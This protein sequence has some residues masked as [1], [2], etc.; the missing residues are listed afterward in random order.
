MNLEQTKTK[1]GLNVLYIDQ[2]DATAGSV[3]MWFR[4]GSA[5][6][7]K[8]DFGVAHFLE[9]MF[10]KG[11]KKRPGAKIADE[12]ESFGGEL[13]AFTSFDFTCYYVNCPKSQLSK[14]VDIILDMVAN[15]QFLQSELIP[16]RG[17]VLEEFKRSIDSP[18]QYAF[19]ELQDNFFSG[20]Y[21]HQILGTEKNIKSFTRDQIVRFRKKYYN[22]ENAL[23][24]VAGDL[25][26]RK[27]ITTLIDKF[28]LPS[29]QKS[30]FSPFELKSKKQFSGHL[31]EVGNTTLQICFEASNYD[32]KEAV[33]EELAL[34]LLGHGESSYLGRKLVYET[35]VANAVHT[36]PL[37]MAKNGIYFLR[38]N[39][40]TENLSQVLKNLEEELKLILKKGI[41]AEDIEKAKF[42]GRTS[43][44]YDLETI[45]AYA[46]SLGNG[47]AQNGDIRS[48]NNFIDR[49]QDVTDQ[50]IKSAMKRILA[51][52]KWFYQ[53]QL[54][55]SENLEKSIGKVSSFDQKLKN[56]L[57]K[58]KDTIKANSPTSEFNKQ[59]QVKT[60]IPGVKLIHRHSSLSKTFNLQ[61]YIKGGLTEENKNSNGKYN[62]LT[63]LL[64]ADTMNK[65]KDESKF[66]FESLAATFSSFCGKNA[67]GLNLS[68]ICE[69]FNELSNQFFDH[70]LN[71]TFNQKDLEFEKLMVKQSLIAQKEDPVRQCFDEVSKIAFGNHPYN[72]KNMGTLE[73][74]ESIELNSLKDLHEG[75]ISNQNL[76]FVYSGPHT[77]ENVTNCISENISNLKKRSSFQ[78]T[79]IKKYSP[80]KIL[81]S[82]LSFDREQTHIFIGKP[83]KKLESKDTI[84]FKLIHTY[85]YGQSSP[86]FTELR[87]K[88]GLCYSVSPVNFNA[89]E[90]G[91]FGIYV[92]CSNGKVKD[93]ITEIN[94]ILSKLREEGLSKSNFKKLIK[95]SV[96]QFELGLQ[97]N[98]DYCNTF[99]TP[100]L[101]GIGLDYYFK[102][103]EQ[104]KDLQYEDFQNGIKKSLGGK[105][106][107]II[108]GANQE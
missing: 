22:K 63:G 108:S 40:P 43:K 54:P 56:S 50:E 20:G 82:Q 9:H 14:S 33:A 10:F 57:N 51:K 58:I 25:K 45:E 78:K 72:M 95:M 99:A 55:K 1:K 59:T 27:K 23:F 64:N 89:L 83:T 101:H 105:F 2:P 67:Y 46:F 41:K 61:V 6:E 11:T 96:G 28:S 7:K 4:A 87:D 60:T 84:Y 62:L 29:G 68:G 19:T 5:L 30:V 37:Y 90:G 91:Y 48:E 103:M 65:T 24:V 31:K 85:L 97:T 17:V 76:L 47:F 98:E 16:E 49:Q 18:S 44:I 107:Q 86:L 53:I 69:K 100:Y 42:Q 21:K 104:I 52:T 38:L 74:I 8:E 3:Q 70:L 66:F 102:E 88:K 35:S 93:S 34:S 13:N 12:V 73:S 77:V 79:K 39:F 75:N 36:S 80:L 26:N 94:R 15:P 106:F 92:G 71:S 81:N 32:S